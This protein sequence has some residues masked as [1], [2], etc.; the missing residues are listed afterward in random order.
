MKL[1]SHLGR[2]YISASI[3]IQRSDAF[4]RC[5]RKHRTSAQQQQLPT[6][7]VQPEPFVVVEP[8]NIII[9]ITT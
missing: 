6:H 1:K 9:V 7:D 4:A 3:C 5:R 8:Q 2:I